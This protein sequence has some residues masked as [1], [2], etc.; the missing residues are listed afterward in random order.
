M[1][2]RE[3][4]FLLL[5]SHLGVPERRPLTPRRLKEIGS[6]AA[7]LR[8]QDPN[9]DLTP[10]HLSA[11]GCEKA[12]AER[13]VSLL[14][15][16]RLLE[17]YLEQGSRHCCVPA[18]RVSR[19][20]P[21]R[22]LSC[23]GEDAP[24]CLWLRGNTALLDVPAIALVGSRDLKEENAAFARAVGELAAREGYAL[25]SGNARGADTQ[26]QESC[27][28]AGGSV[29]CVVADRL[30][31]HPV[32]DRVLYI[33]EEGFDLPFTPQRALSRNRVIHSM[34]QK[35]FVAQC[36]PG[37]GGTWKGTL[38]N[39]KG[40]WSDVFCFADGS[41]GEESLMTL[42]ATPISVEELHNIQLWKI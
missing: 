11:V 33:S 15:E 35:A 32:R 27:L 36:S 18:T 20:Y 28:G 17:N 26:A 30:M 22:L 37:S 12:L 42:G 25:I 9:Q 38:Q 5:T 16:W 29:I 13:T 41:A 10:E 40:R 34:A 6:Y 2:S 14:S 39:L 23:L 3:K 8:T 4:G 7:K 1:N 19:D 21:S 31:D 24:G